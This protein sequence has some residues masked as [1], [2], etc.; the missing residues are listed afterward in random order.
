MHIDIFLQK[1]HG[2][3][4]EERSHRVLFMWAPGSGGMLAL[5]YRAVLDNQV[6]R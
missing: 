2:L 1:L 6:Y 4:R 3:L 5:A